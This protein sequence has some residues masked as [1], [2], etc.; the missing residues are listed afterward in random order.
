M[1]RKGEGG[2]NGSMVSKGLH[3]HFFKKRFPREMIHAAQTRLTRS[4]NQQSRDKQTTFTKSIKY[5][6]SCSLSNCGSIHAFRFFLIKNGRRNLISL[7]SRWDGIFK[8][9]S[10]LFF[11]FFFEFYLE[12][13]SMIS[14]RTGWRVALLSRDNHCQLSA[15]C[16]L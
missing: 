10:N 1:K 6:Y 9:V 11:L 14:K 15:V 7:I 3:S 4:E 8:S 13:R 12:T 16:K 5:A 2:K